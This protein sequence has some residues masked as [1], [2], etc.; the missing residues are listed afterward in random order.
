MLNLVK[1]GIASLVSLRKKQPFEVVF[2]LYYKGDGGLNGALL[3]ATS[4][5][6]S[7]P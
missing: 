6:V 2:L 7:S 5:A 1:F 4:E 3:A